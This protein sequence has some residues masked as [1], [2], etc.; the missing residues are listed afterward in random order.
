MPQRPS[1]VDRCPG[2]V[3]HKMRMTEWSSR[4]YIP[5]ALQNGERESDERDVLRRLCPIRALSG[6]FVA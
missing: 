6:R 2:A 5:L 3:V 4:R 1:A